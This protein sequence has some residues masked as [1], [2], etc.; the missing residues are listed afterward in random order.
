MQRMIYHKNRNIKKGTDWSLIC[1]HILKGW[2]ISSQNV[3]RNEFCWGKIPAIDH[4]HKNIKWLRIIFAITRMACTT[5]ND[6]IEWKHFPRY[7]PFVRGIQRSRVNSPHKASDAELWCFLYI[8]L[9]KLSSK[10]LWVWLF[11]SP[12]RSLWRHCHKSSGS[13]IRIFRWNR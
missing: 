10:Q 7:W 13:D 8:C 11:E 9:N 5:H 1:T 12:S 3:I 4:W 2:N 6:V